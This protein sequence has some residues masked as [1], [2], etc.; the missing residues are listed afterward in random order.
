MP[1]GRPTD[2]DPAYI[3]QI[4]DYF[5][6]EAGK[7]IPYK[8]KDGELKTVRVAADFPT[9]AGFACKIGVHR[10]TLHEWAQQHPA[11][12]DAYKMAKQHQERILVQNGLKGGYH[13]NFAIFTAKN[14][15]E[16]RD[17]QDTEITG[18]GGGPV[19]I[20]TLERVIVR[21]HAADTDR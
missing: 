14:V 20:T 16:W 15:I 9:L 7:D 1:A 5:S 13:A 10:D 21:P 6:I 17:K 2:Y 18:P 19:Q 8:G 11:F 3:D 12:S 4:S